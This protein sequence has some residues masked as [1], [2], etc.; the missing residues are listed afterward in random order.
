MRS[1][2]IYDSARLA[3]AYAYD[4]PPVHQRILRTIADRLRITTRRRRAL[5]VGC[6]A[7]LSTAALEPLAE[8]VLGLEPMLRM[9]EHSPDVAPHAH[10]VAGRAERL[11]F[12]SQAFDLLTA[13]GSLD[14]VNLD[15]FFPEAHRVLAPDGVLV[16]YDFS[17]GRRVRGSNAL[18]EWYSEFE[19]RYPAPVRSHLD[20]R[21]LAYRPFGLHLD[22]Y[23]AIEVAVPMTCNS[24]LRYISSESRVELAISRGV[25]EADVREWCQRTL[26]DVFGDESLDVVF[27]AYVAC[28]TR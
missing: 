8:I 9:L 2:N 28:V 15:L 11:P 4:R 17:A 23:E 7:G 13:A 25:P 22:S 6:G 14:Y 27:D 26:R 20:V 10:F 16:V 3:A 21:S 12:S 24:Y 18:G 5:D 1:E 19:R